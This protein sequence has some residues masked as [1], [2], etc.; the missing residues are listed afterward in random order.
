MM[1]HLS[2]R[3]QLHLQSDASSFGTLRIRI[4]SCCLKWNLLCRYT[5]EAVGHLLAVLWVNVGFYIDAY[6]PFILDLADGSHEHLG[7]LLFIYCPMSNEKV[8]QQLIIFAPPGALCAVLI[9]CLVYVLPHFLC[10][11]STADHFLKG[12]TIWML[13]ALPFIHMA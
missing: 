6:F 2:L 13:I 4:N 7:R 8:K 1:S 3:R 12:S 5:H 10:T 11:D 9:S